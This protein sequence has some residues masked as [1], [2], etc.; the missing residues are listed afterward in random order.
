MCNI[1]AGVNAGA[2]RA[3]VSFRD[4]T[5]AW[6]DKRWQSVDDAT[7]RKRAED[8]GNLKKVREL[9][10]DA[11]RGGWTFGARW[12]ETNLRAT[13]AARDVGQMKKTA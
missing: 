7:H 13:G 3:D 5:I 12:G 8:F 11:E 2:R 1:D 6:D 9:K 4:V 10:L